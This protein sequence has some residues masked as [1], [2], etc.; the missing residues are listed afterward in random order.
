MTKTAKPK[1]VKCRYK[2]C[3]HE[4]KELNAEDAV[5]V[6]VSAYY[7]QDCYKTKQ[8]IDEITKVFTERVNKNV[9]Y[10]QLIRAINNIIFDKGNESGFLLYALNYCIDHGWKLQ[11][12]GGLYSVVQNKDAETAYQKMKQ[13]KMQTEQQ[14]NSIFTVED[15]QTTTFTYTTQKNKGFGVILGK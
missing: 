9:V 6:G 11:Y 4:S 12:P 1:M 14:K 7:H 2:H 15:N 3:F 13:K 8:D 5:K 10:P